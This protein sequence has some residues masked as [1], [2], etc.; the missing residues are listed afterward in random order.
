[1]SIK[2]FLRDTEGAAL[3][4]YSVLIGMVSGCV[5][6]VIFAISLSMEA[7]L[8]NVSNALTSSS[9][10]VSIANSAFESAD[11]QGPA[12][13]EQA[14]TS[15]ANSSTSSG[16]NS[17]ANSGSD[18]GGGCAGN[19]QSGKGNNCSNPNKSARNQ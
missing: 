7:N 18:G 1:M 4:E 5:L 3:V 14:E 16:A 17:G 2:G 13:S 11:Q 8:G 19:S 12:S 9:N 10:P 15:L 6:G